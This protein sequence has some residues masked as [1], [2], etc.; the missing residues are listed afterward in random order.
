[1]LFS[2][3]LPGQAYPN[4]PHSPHTKALNNPSTALAGLH[5]NLDRQEK[6]ASR[7]TDNSISHTEYKYRIIELK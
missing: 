3:P 4:P 7:K 6:Q 1:M 2:T 5:T